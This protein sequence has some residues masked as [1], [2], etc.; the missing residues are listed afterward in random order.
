MKKK[1]SIRLT[2]AA[3]LTSLVFSSC[4]PTTTKQTEETST[5][6]NVSRETSTQETTTTQA[7]TSAKVEESTQASTTFPAL[8]EGYQYGWVSIT[9]RL[10]VRK[11]ANKKSDIVGHIKYR[12]RVVVKGDKK[13]KGF[14]KIT[15]TDCDTGKKISGYCAVKYITFKQPASAKVQLNVPLY[16]QTDDRWA[17]VTLGNSGRT[18]YDIGCT[19]SCLAM[20]ES[21]LQKKEILPSDMEKKLYYTSR[22]SLGWPLKYDFC[23]DK[24]VYLEV[25]LEKLHKGIPVL[26]GSERKNGRPHWVLITGYKGNGEEL[27]EKDF[28]INDPLPYNRTTLAQYRKEY[29]VFIKL[30]F[31]TGVDRVDETKKDTKKK[32]KKTTTKKT[33]KTS[34]KKKKTSKKKS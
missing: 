31:Y 12:Q 9:G 29:P 30:A 34:D 33:T 32:T 3:V 27:K 26:I 21:F 17:K 24:S 2:V 13:K 4:T 23:Y 10:N 20:S 28:I 22:G 16:L 14:Y 8:K 19:T 7:Q 15:A 18:I 6:Q 11:K 5:T 1:I 25:V